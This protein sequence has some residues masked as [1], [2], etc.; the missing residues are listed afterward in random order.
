MLA[1]IAR[2]AASSQARSFDDRLGKNVWGKRE[3]PIQLW[4]KLVGS[5]WR[6]IIGATRLGATGPRV[7]EREIFL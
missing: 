2:R 7:S 3:S 5:S 1:S 6:K 4:L